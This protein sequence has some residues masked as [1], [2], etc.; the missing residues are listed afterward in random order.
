[1]CNAHCRTVVD[2]QHLS[3]YYIERNYEN[4][5]QAFSALFN[6]FIITFYDYTSTIQY[7]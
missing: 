7:C 1:M 4:M 3:T 6:V 5:M 2:H